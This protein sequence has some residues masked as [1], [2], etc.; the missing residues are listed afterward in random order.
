[1][2]YLETDGGDSLPPKQKKTCDDR[3]T[4]LHPPRA[5]S[6]HVDG[7]LRFFNAGCAPD[8]LPALQ[9]PSPIPLFK[10]FS[11]FCSCKRVYFETDLPRIFSKPW[12]PEA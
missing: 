4:L 7:A 12:S 3:E 8:N 10:K 9:A 6:P 11:H 1:M 5:P 2:V